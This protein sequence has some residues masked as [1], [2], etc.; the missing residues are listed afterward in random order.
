[1][2]TATVA[3]SLQ[4][5]IMRRGVVVNLGVASGKTVKVGYSFADVSAE[6]GVD[7]TATNDT[8]TFTPS[9][10][11]GLTP[12]SLFIPF[13]IIQDNVNEA[14]ET[15]TIT[16]SEPSDANASVD[17]ENKLV[18][19]SITDDDTT[20]PVVSI[21]KAEGAEGNGINNGKITFTISLTFIGWN[22]GCCWS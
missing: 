15:F 11:T 18:T 21:A 6:Q 13:S 1:M 14:D 3:R 17:D 2:A 20:L 5:R 19:V 22:L 8:L 4:V 9:A 10:T 12:T 16:L 7:Y